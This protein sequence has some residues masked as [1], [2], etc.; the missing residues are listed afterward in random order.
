MTDP[1]LF[2]LPAAA[3]TT[4]L[5]LLFLR[6]AWH[7]A[8]EFSGFTGFVADYRL[9]P[10]ALVVPAA[11]ALVAAEFGALALLAVPATAAVG[12]M[13]AAGLLTL[14]AVAMAVN[15]M[16]GHRRIECGCGGAPQM[17][18]VALIVRNGLLTADAAL[19]VVGGSG[20]LSVGEAVASVAAGLLLFLTLTV[21]EQVLANDGLLRSAP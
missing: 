9:L 18:S 5:A 2:N 12:A 4:L 16:R 15:I 21:V 7:K 1:T 3:G 10:A 20:S 11:A 6:A 13:A 8:G 17:L 14:Y 19:V